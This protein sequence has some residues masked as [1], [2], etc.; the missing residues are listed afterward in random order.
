MRKCNKTTFFLLCLCTVQLILLISHSAYVNQLGSS[1]RKSVTGSLEISNEPQSSKKENGKESITV[2]VGIFSY[3]LFKDRRDGIRD[4]WGSLCRANKLAVCKF[5]IDGLDN[6]GQEIPEGRKN[7]ILTESKKYDDITIMDSYA[8][9]NFLYRLYRTLIWASERY[10]FDYFVR[11]DDDH[12]LCFERLMFE[13]PQRRE[14]K[15]MYWGFQHCYKGGVRID[16]GLLI[17]SE[18]LIQY[19]MGRKE[20]LKCTPFEDIGVS[21]WVH[22]RMEKENIT[23]FAD[24]RIFH[25]QVKKFPDLLNRTQICHEYLSLHGSYVKEM[26]LLHEIFLKE[27]TLNLPA[28]EV[29]SS[30][31]NKCPHDRSKFL[32]PAAPL[33]IEPPDTTQAKLYIGR[34]GRME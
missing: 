10:N 31:V 4:S 2:F 17:M 13:L 8:G 20:N 26:P 30:S 33:C 16:P 34:E 12:Y 19:F 27:K 11:I 1:L 3:I 7:T 32:N 14:E 24:E 21:I 25:K 9:K 28:Y 6:L 15:N 18:D 29:T 5:I 22:Q 23:W